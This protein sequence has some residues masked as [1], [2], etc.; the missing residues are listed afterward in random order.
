MPDRMVSHYRIIECLGGGAMGKVYKAEDTLLHRKVALKF[1]PADLTGDEEASSRFMREARATSSLDH[2]N[3]CTIHEIAQ[4]EDG[5]WYIAMAWYDGQTLKKIIDKGALP[6]DRALGLAR[7]AA[8]GL[9]QAHEHDVVHRDVKPDNIMIS[10]KDELTILDFGLARLLGKA[11]LTRTGTVMGTAAYMSPEQ[12]RGEDVGTSSDIWSLG[13]VLYEMLSGHVPFEG[14]SDVAMMYSVLNTDP[15][16]LPAPVCRNSEICTSIIQH[17]LA[18]DPKD[19]YPTAQVMAEEIELAIGGSKS[20]YDSK[21]SRSSIFAPSARPLWLR[22]LPAVIALA[23]LVALAFPQSRDFL[24]SISPFPSAERPVGVA[25]IPFTLTG[26]QDDAEA[27]G[28]GLSYMINDRLAGLE[29]Y[30]DRF[31][32]VAADEI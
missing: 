30:S 6:P 5:S 3:I 2:P 25:V 27:F 12:A 31:W 19:R 20:A 22:L 4:A 23:L 26:D 24:R 21:L 32:V 8:L 10:H 17:C 13:V 15:P 7:Q 1:L 29:Q 28:R 11:R 9:S 16:P 18:R 14:E